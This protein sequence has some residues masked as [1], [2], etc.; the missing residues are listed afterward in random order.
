AWV[1]PLLLVAVTLVLGRETMHNLSFANETRGIDALLARM[2]PKR[3]LLYVPVNPASSST[4]LKLVYLHYALWYQAR[5]G[6]LVE[7]NF[8]TLLPQIVRYREFRRHVDPDASWHPLERMR[9][10]RFQDDDYAYV[11]FR[12]D[13][14]PGTARSAPSPTAR[15]QMPSVREAAE[16][17]RP[18]TVIQRSGAEENA[19]M[20]SMASA[21]ILCSGYLV[22]PARRG[23]RS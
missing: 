21:T 22:S 8:A 15:A 7:F 16:T 11:L 18:S 4:D 2:P 9:W 14:P 12:S 3:K 23:S 19:R 6:G 13:S 5:H 17:T 20:P 1:M 10:A